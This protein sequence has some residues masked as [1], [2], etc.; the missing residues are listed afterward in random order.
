MRS[1]GIG[2]SRVGFVVFASVVLNLAGFA[3]AR[4]G[5]IAILAGDSN[6]THDLYVVNPDNGDVTRLT[7]DDISDQHVAG[8]PRRDVIA[9]TRWSDDPGIYVIRTDGTG[10][11]NLTPDAKFA[12]APAWSPDGTRIAYVAYE[13]KDGSPDIMLMDEDGGNSKS[14]TARDTL[15]AIAPELQWTPDG[16]EIWYQVGPDNELRYDIY[17]LNVRTGRTRFVMDSP[18]RHTR[19]SRDG[20]QIAFYSVNLYRL[21]ISNIRGGDIRPFGALGK[22]NHPS[23]SPDGK[24]LAYAQTLSWGKGADLTDIVIHDISTS[25]TR[26]VTRLPLGVTGLDWFGGASRDDALANHLPTAW[27]ELKR[28]VESE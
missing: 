14:L 1:L 18:G 17:S 19:L 8:S 2:A 28:S 4:S 7:N 12:L 23:W 24:H 15:P 27:G 21:A 26:T 10:L 22:V 16:Q 25:Q 3:Y 20:K 9:F 6:A 13:R 11:T 5:A